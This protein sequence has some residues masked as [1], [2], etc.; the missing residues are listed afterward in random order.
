MPYAQKQFYSQ[1]AACQSLLPMNVITVC[2]DYMFL[3]FLMNVLSGLNSPPS[4]VSPNSSDDLH[5][6]RPLS[7]M[8]FS[9]SLHLRSLFFSQQLKGLVSVSQVLSSYIFSLLPLCPAA[10]RHSSAQSVF[11]SECLCLAVPYLF[12]PS[13]R[14]SLF[15]R[16][17][18]PCSQLTMDNP[19]FQS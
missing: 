12:L 10:F 8:T 13:L 15:H 17:L 9:I 7:P 19:L 14:I 1:A 18:S 6:P 16:F 3:A 5:S 11:L 4:L 2:K